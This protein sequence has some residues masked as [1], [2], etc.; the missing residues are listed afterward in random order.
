MK[1]KTV[2]IQGTAS[3]V[4]KSI[5]TAAI[6][7]ILSN[8]GYKVAPFKAQNMSHNSY[9]TIDGGE[10]SRAQAAQAEAARVELIKEMN[11]ILLKPHS[12]QRSQVIVD[13]RVVGNFLGTE[14]Y[15]KRDYLLGRVKAA[16]DRLMSDY[17]YLVIEGA[18]SPAEINLQA[19]DIVN[20]KTAELADAPV[21]LVA[22]IDMGGMFAAIVGTFALLKPE[23]QQRIKGIIINKFRGQLSLLE[24][25]IKLLENKIDRPILGVIP[26]ISNIQID[27]EDSVALNN[28]VHNYKAEVELNIGVI[29]LPHI[30]NFTDFNALDKEKDVN[31]NYVTESKELH[32]VDALII[33]GSKSTIADLDYLYKRKLDIMIKELARRAVPIIGICG[34]YQILGVS[35]RDVSE[36]ES[37]DKYAAG[38][39]VLPVE[40][41]L[42]Q[43]KLTR[44]S[45]AKICGYGPMLADV[46]SLEITGYE[47][48]MGRT[49]KLDGCRPFAKFLGEEKFDGAVD[50]AG[51]VM[52]TYFHGIFD[53]DIFR[54]RWLDFLRDRKG[55]AKANDFKYLKYREIKDEAYERLA[56]VVSDNLNMKLL[57]EIIE[58]GH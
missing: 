22:D 36:T 4:G 38:L 27:D 16:L 14:Y 20:M 55:L 23:Q 32:G 56:Q 37:S 30:S 46:D 42:S 3:N 41:E 17:D 35:I 47:V 26:H 19:H 6:C 18:G 12:D 51:L 49:V 2:M 52:G 40:T 25:G 15:N 33:P 24:P 48:H 21:I 43:D 45:L 39:A 31:L 29:K 28:P 57:Y 8:K 10:V 5:I 50:N 13:G 44:R 9:I 53:N 1:A 54:R 34:G 11:P 7:R 58:N